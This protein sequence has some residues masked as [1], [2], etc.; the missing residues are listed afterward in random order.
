MTQFENAVKYGERQAGDVDPRTGS[1]R[2]LFR[3]EQGGITVVTDE[4]QTREV[5]S[6]T[7]PCWGVNLEKVHIT[8]DMKKS[9]YRADQDSKHARHRWNSHAVAVVDQSGSMRETDAEGGVTRSDLVWLCLAI[10]YIGKRIR[11]GEA[12]QKDYFS[13]VLMG[14]TATCV[15]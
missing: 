13:L 6:W 10:D 9:H 5:T 1:Q 11:T 7:H 8:E 4:S 2:W 12:T 15:P 14:P 3:Y